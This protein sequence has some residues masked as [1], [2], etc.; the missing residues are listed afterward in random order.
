MSDPWIWGFREGQRNALDRVQ[1][2]ATKFA[3]YTNDSGWENLALRRK[4]TGICDLFKGH[5]GEPAW[6]C[7]G[8][9]W[10]GPCYLSRDDHDRKIRARKRRT[11]IGKYCFVNRTV[12]LW[13]QLPAEALATLACKSHLYRKRARKLVMCGKKWRV[14]EEWWRN[15]R[16]Y[17]DVK[18]GKWRAVKWSEVMWWSWVKCVY[19]HWF[20]VM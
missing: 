8:D 16:K 20:L 2:K 11:D 7:I 18:K 19:Y 6:K 14:F 15:V 4:I 9:R 12:K 17:R 13:N 10:K 1:K 3:I 5:I